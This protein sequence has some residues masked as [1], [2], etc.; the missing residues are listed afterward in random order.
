M[1]FIRLSCGLLLAALLPA[2][3]AETTNP[4]VADTKPPTAA[5]Q[6]ARV[7]NQILD[8]HAPVLIDSSVYA[9]YPLGLRSTDGAKKDS[10]SGDEYGG[11]SGVGRSNTYWNVV[12]YNTAT[13]TAHLLGETRKMIIYSFGPRLAGGNSADGESDY[14]VGQPRHERGNALIYYEVRINDFNKDGTI[15]EKDPSYLFAS[16][17]AGDNFRQLSPD[18]YNVHE[19]RLLKGANKI[20]LRATAAT[21]DN[22][23]Y[24]EDEQIVPFVY[25]LNTQGPARKIFSPAFQTSAKKLLDSL[26]V[27]GKQQ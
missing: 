5:E 3:G 27:K 10:G 14:N 21:A 19:W 18:N 17:M 25:D 2:C 1:T 22:R 16:D 7:E 4:V 23:S 26:W 8:F 11:K 20:L 15:D 9:M 24:G 13:G 6:K 12:F